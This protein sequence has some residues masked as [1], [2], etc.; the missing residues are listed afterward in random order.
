VSVMVYRRAH[1]TGRVVQEIVHEIGAFDNLL[2]ALMAVLHRPRAYST[3]LARP[4]RG[5]RARPYLKQGPFGV[6]LVRKD[7]SPPEEE[8]WVPTSERRD[9]DGSS[10]WLAP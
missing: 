1:L 4:C 7:L 5:R 6:G 3:T 9:G 10:F 8:E 2:R